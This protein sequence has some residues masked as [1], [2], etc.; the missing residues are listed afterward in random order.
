[1]RV[2]GLLKSGIKGLDEAVGG[3]PD[4]GV[5][6]IAGGPGIGKTVMAAQFIYN[7]AVMFGERGV[8]ASFSESKE[9]FYGNMLAFGMNFDELEKKGL[10][11]FLSLMVLS[12]ES[13]VSCMD[14]ILEALTAAKARRVVLD[15]INAVTCMMDDG[16]VR[17]FVQ[18]LRAL[19]KNTGAVCFLIYE[20]SSEAK[21]EEL[22]PIAF[23][24]DTVLLLRWR[25][26]ENVKVRELE[27][28]KS[29]G[30][31]V[32]KG[33]Y[34]FDVDRK[35]GGEWVI[36]PPRTI[37]S[38][39]DEVVSTGL[40]WL[41]NAI[42]GGLRRGSFTLVKGE[43]G[44]GKTCLC[45]QLAASMFSTGRRCIYVSTEEG[46]GVARLLRSFKLNVECGSEQLKIMGITPEE[47]DAQRIYSFFDNLVCNEKPDL[48]VI[49]SLTPFRRSLP[50]ARFYRFLRFIQLLARTKGVA[51]V[52]T[53]SFSLIEEAMETD[54]LGL[55][56]NLL[57]LR[58]APTDGA[59]HKLLFLVKVRGGEHRR[60]PLRIEVTSRG[61]RPV[62]EEG[63][64]PAT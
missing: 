25:E 54:M 46:E 51:V 18:L 12:K 22:G 52:A 36:A 40:E 56:D 26:E 10:F 58:N 48:L 28:L 24:A 61:V 63:L 20:A 43:T 11:R 23:M 33:F 39:G 15:S 41:N 64:M 57:V 19:I 35:H 1:M 27:V 59:P 29:R 62:S 16:E 45:V 21:S 47:Y 31:P 3:L 30:S 37:P 13:L 49:D 9:E 6:V 50:Q 17:R 60:T 44:A 8:Y 7:G 2:G 34:D 5:V 38:E 42:G 14:E 55:F 53:F 32:E 4:R